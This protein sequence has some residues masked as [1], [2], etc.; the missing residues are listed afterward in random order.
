VYSHPREAHIL[1]K[2]T[3]AKIAFKKYR[4]PRGGD[5][6]L[7][8]LIP[9]DTDAIPEEVRTPLQPILSL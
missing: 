7:F 1:L 8:T 6:Q 3:P 4:D 5:K 9:Q 2:G